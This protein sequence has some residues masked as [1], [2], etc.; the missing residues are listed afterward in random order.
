MEFS[1]DEH[2]FVIQ[3]GEKLCIDRSSSAD[4]FYVRHKNIKISID[5]TPCYK[6][7]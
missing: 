1:F 7:K 2:A 6:V 3:K 4:P 5:S